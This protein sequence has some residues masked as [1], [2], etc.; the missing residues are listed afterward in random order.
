MKIKELE[1]AQKRR[2][3]LKSQ[4]KSNIT[5]TTDFLTTVYIGGKLGDTY[6]MHVSLSLI[7]SV[8]WRVC[9]MMWPVVCHMT[10][11]MCCT[12]YVTWPDACQN[13]DLLELLYC[14]C[15]HMLQCVTSYNE[16]HM[17]WHDQLCVTWPA[18]CHMTSFASHDRLASHDLSHIMNWCHV[19]CCVTWSLFLSDQWCLYSS[20]CGGGGDQSQGP[21]AWLLCP[22]PGAGWLGVPSCSLLCWETS[23]CPLLCRHWALSLSPEKCLLGNPQSSR[24]SFSRIVTWAGHKLRVCVGCCM[25]CTQAACSVKLSNNGHIRTS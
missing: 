2:A 8:T 21:P 1:E 9:H 6:N 19:T 17:T 14:V 4:K 18:L 22:L 25:V 12:V 20:R 11:F 13:Y 23:R 24:E 5:S 16:C 7:W 10:C 3:E 15:L